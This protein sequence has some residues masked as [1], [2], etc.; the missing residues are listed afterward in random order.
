MNLES[1]SIFKSKQ[2]ESENEK[3]DVFTHVLHTTPVGRGKSVF[4]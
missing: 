2:E 1:D 4:Q 3:G